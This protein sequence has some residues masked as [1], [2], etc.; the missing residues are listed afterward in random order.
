M[1]KHLLLPTD[2]SAI[3]EKAIAAS[4]AFAKTMGAS[5]TGL[6]VMPD[7]QVLQYATSRVEDSAAQFAAET[8]RHADQFLGVIE[9]AASAAGVPFVMLRMRS[10]H[11]YEAIIEAARERAC[12]LIAMASHGR[13][14]VK[15][16][17]LGSETQKVL[18]NSQIPVLVFR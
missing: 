4:V 16:F 2:G 8:A 5:I 10:D 18:T 9:K 6:Y 13:K 14:G 12:D 15:G 17:L 11:P 3:S 7:Y 1:F